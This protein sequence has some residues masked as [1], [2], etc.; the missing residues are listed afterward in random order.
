MDSIYKKKYLKYKKKYETQKKQLMKGGVQCTYRAVDDITKTETYLT[1]QTKKLSVVNFPIGNML[2]FIDRIISIGDNTKKVTAV[3]IKNTTGK[4]I[5]NRLTQLINSFLLVKMDVLNEYLNMVSYVYKD[6][7]RIYSHKKYVNIDNPECNSSNKYNGFGQNI[8]TDIDTGFQS[9]FIFKG[10]NVIKYWTL[11]SYI[12]K[13]HKLYVHNIEDL[14]K[15]KLGENVFD[16]S[17]DYDFQMY[18]QDNANNYTMDVY[19]KLLKHLVHRMILLREILINQLFK[20]DEYDKNENIDAIEGYINGD[21]YLIDL[22]N[23][24]RSS[25]AAAEESNKIYV[26]KKSTSFILTKY[27]PDVNDMFTSF[28]MEEDKPL[29]MSFNN[30]ITTTTNDDFDLFRLKLQFSYDGASNNKSAEFYDMTILRPNDTNTSRKDFCNNV[31][32]YST[33]VTLDYLKSN[34]QLRLYSVYY[35]LKDLL[36]ILFSS[37]MPRNSIFIWSDSKYE[38]RIL[39]LGYINSLHLNKQYNHVCGLINK[40]GHHSTGTISLKSIGEYTVTSNPADTNLSKLSLLSIKFLNDYILQFMLIYFCVNFIKR[41]N[42]GNTSANTFTLELYAEL[43]S[44]VSTILHNHNIPDAVHE[45][46]YGSIYPIFDKYASN[47][48]LTVDLTEVKKYIDDGKFFH[49]LL[50]V[51]LIYVNKIFVQDDLVWCRQNYGVDADINVFKGECRKYFESFVDYSMGGLDSLTDLMPL[52]VPNS[53]SPSYGGSVDVENIENNESLERLKRNLNLQTT[54]NHNQT[55][56]KME[57]QNS[58]IGHQMKFNDFMK[59][60]TEYSNIGKKHQLFVKDTGREYTEQHGEDET[61]FVKSKTVPK[62]VNFSVMSS[63]EKFDL[64]TK[65]QRDKISKIL[66]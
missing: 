19:Q 34:I 56:R 66:S 58:N 42:N 31:N 21:K 52:F 64:I 28:D 13:R 22:L 49:F 33:I 44:F 50:S 45:K 59:D 35:I 18:I 46:I 61:D 62:E 8:S 63:D 43:K 10:G 11:S 54:Y 65:E 20:L 24:P 27:N 2:Q 26:A 30:T 41:I 53:P 5:N 25:T 60:I 40:Q 17:S 1:G 48:T 55:Q 6:F 23:K 12:H 36:K 15:Y 29:N 14:L 7:D 38:K 16:E 4:Q 47:D 37:N 3:N 32:K 9:Y 39:R 57:H 51:N